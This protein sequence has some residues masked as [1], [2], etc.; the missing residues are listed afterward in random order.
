MLTIANI[1][2]LVLLKEIIALYSENNL[3]PTNTLCG[4]NAK[5][6]IVKEG[7]TYSYHKL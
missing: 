7:G 3:K 5:L 4:Q 2:W 1:N 6:L